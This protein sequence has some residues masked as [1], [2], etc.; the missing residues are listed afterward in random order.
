MRDS[1]GFPKRPTMEE[2]DQAVQAILRD[3]AARLSSRGKSKRAA[4]QARI[5]ANRCIMKVDTYPDL[6]GHLETIANALGCPT[7]Q[8]VNRVL[9]SG[10]EKLTLEDLKTELIPCRSMRYPYTLPYPNE[11]NFK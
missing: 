3:G 1:N 6:K 2:P 9:L 5:D 11:S 10:L 7:S 4:R 8:V